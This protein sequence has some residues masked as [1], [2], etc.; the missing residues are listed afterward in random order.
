MA[1][2]PLTQAEQEAILKAFGGGKTGFKQGANRSFEADR[3][4]R[5]KAGNSPTSVILSVEDVKGQY[6]ASRALM[7]TL[8]GMTRKIDAPELEAFRRNIE[9]V[10]KAYK[11][12]IKADQ[13]L[14]LSLDD[15]LIRARKEIHTGIPTRFQGNTLHFMTNAGPDSDVKQ[16]YVTIKFLDLIA[17]ATTPIPL[18]TATKQV[19]QGY[20]AFDCDCRRHRYWYRYISTIGGFNAG[21]AETGFPKIRNPHLS[22]VACKHVLRV[23]TALS[24]ALAISKIKEMVK[25]ARQSVQPLENLPEQQ[26]SAKE[27]KDA[28]K[29]QL[30]RAHHERNQVRRAIDDPVKQRR[31]K[32]EAERL[33]KATQA[34]IQRQREER[35]RIITS[36]S[37]MERLNLRLDLENRVKNLQREYSISANDSLL[38][39]IEN[40][41]ND[42]SRL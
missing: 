21:R 25:I 10:R 1:L 18:L 5:E 23:M 34:N 12:G 3:L 26:L 38:D 40:L 2:N 35:K 32:K 6:D 42:I 33:A 28:A 37:P 15:D 22:G 9:T 20:L 41:Q 7:T 17:I 14:N 16:H 39:A 24:Q 31:A 36:G 19:A 27:V 4:S 30:A 13:V 29:Q 8:G 11:S